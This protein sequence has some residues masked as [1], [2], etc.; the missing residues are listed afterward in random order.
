ME[1]CGAAADLVLAH[2]ATIM[3]KATSKAAGMEPTALGASIAR[4]ALIWQD[5]EEAAKSQ[6]RALATTP[7]HTRKALTMGGV[8]SR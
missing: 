4:A 5:D 1:Q 2:T 8:S 7:S 6:L 3:V